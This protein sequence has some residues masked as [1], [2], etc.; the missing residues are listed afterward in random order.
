MKKS[1]VFFLLFILLIGCAKL[2][3]EVKAPE[4]ALVLLR[5]E[6]IPRFESDLDRESLIIAIGWSIDYLERLP[7]D[8]LFEYGEDQYSVAHLIQSMETFLYLVHQAEDMEEL[9]DMIRQRF[10][11]YQSV[12]SD[13]GGSVLYTGYY[14][15]IL[16]GSLIPNETYRWPLYRKPDDLMVI[17]LELFKSKFKG[18]RIVARYDGN[19]VVPFFTREEIDNHGALAGRQLEVVWL[20]DL[21]DI[22]FLQIQGSGQIVLEDGS[23]LRV[24][25]SASNG[26]PYRSI[27]GFLIHKGI[28]TREEMTIPRLREYLMDNPDQREKILNYNES[29]VF[30]RVVDDGPLGNIE[31]PLTPGRS[32]ATDSRLFPKGGLVYIS[33]EKPV[34][35]A[36]GNVKEWVPFSRFALNQDTGG[37]IKGP[38]RVDLFWGSGEEAGTIAGQIRTEGKLY[39]LVAK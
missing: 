18:E 6:D 19:R 20:E 36:S 31:V 3:K 37:A 27:G 17:D 38:G 26:R 2:T 7:E 21:V 16:E 1:L 12:G 8:R 10:N 29:Y 14:E 28:I 11:V 22:F 34:I 13:G 25:Y 33:S 32:I 5:D 24:N 9:T 23:I 39:F 30:F 35:D 15:P 4:K